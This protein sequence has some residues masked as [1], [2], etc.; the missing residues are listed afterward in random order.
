M[1]FQFGPH[2]V[3][4][5]TSPS[6]PDETKG[7]SCLWGISMSRV[8]TQEVERFNAAMPFHVRLPIP[9]EILA[10]DRG[11]G[12]IHCHRDVAEFGLEHDQHGLRR[13]MGAAQA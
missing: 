2:S 1:M 3:F 6:K 10:G 13:Q 11:M 9:Q 5:A 4:N 8:L 7:D 12:D